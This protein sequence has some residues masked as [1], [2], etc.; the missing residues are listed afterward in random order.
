MLTPVEQMLFILLALL[1]I[2]AAYHG[3]REMWLVINRGQGKLYL[4][5]LPARAWKALTIYLS[6]NTTLKTRRLTSLLHLGIVW[7]FTFYFLVNALDFLIGFVAGFEETLK[8]GG[9]IYD[10]YRFLADV[11]SVAVIVGVVYFILRR[12]T[13]PSKKEL[14]FH[15]NVLVHPKVSAGSMARDS[16]I[17]A[18]FIL[19]HVG[20]RFM[21]EAVIVAQQGEPDLFMPFATLVAPLF[22]GFSADGLQMMR[23]LM[24]WLALGG[25]LLFMPYFPYTKHAHLFMAPLNFLTR[26]PRT[27]I[28]EM[29]A[30]D[31]ED[32]EKEQFG[33]NK[34]EDLTMTNI[35][36]G[37]ACIMCNRCQDVCPAY[38]TGKELSP[39]AYEI[40]KRF[41][42]K[43]QMFDL[44]EGE[45]SLNPLIGSAISES[46]V[47]ACTACGACIDICPVGNEPMLDILD[48]RRDAVLVQGEFPGDLQAAFNGMER[49][50][51]PWQIGEARFRWANGLDFPVPTVEE[52]PDF[53]I[54]YWV[55]CAASYDP[56]A[57]LTARALVKVLHQAGVNF[58]VLGEQENCTGDS[59]RRAGNE[60]LF[61]E[62]AMGNVETLNEVSPPRIVVTCPH[63]FHNIGKEYHQFGGNY[64]VVHH[65][66]LIEELI[67]Q[68]RVPMEAHPNRM[69]NVTFHDPCYLGRHNDVVDAPRNVLE[70][71]GNPSVEMPRNRKNSFCC[72]AGGAQ[73]WKEEE[74][75]EKAVNV[76]RYEEAKN[77]GAEVMAV[78]CPFCMQMFESAQADVGGEGPV[79]K[80]IAE[81]IAERLPGGMPASEDANAEGAGD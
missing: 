27:S 75:G 13:L 53:E 25:I 31:F 12:F 17:V 18:V 10:G 62:L 52:N 72:G 8:T 47:W 22:A 50:G 81:L 32:E 51:N 36:D 23:H 33:A 48:I 44:S 45:V 5:N 49:Q 57:Q 28:G 58:A 15:D 6:Q 39:S 78:G 56:R 60:Y 66:E 77:T 61:Q 74:H 4:E 26:P 41:L 80:D 76:E 38:V 1:S 43:D 42:I 7:G 14:T 11:F 30:L 64:E 20:A 34:L 73:F 54:L 79:V 35:L 65:T 71:L 70:R 55:G 3:F 24:W 16:L 9:V 2:G 37:F 46:A 19:I 40:N 21:G 69:S 67:A 59:A 29:E 68:G 63:C